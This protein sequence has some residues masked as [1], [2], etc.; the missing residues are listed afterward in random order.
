MNYRP[1]NSQILIKEIYYLM[2]E[3]IYYV[4]KKK[5]FTSP[6]ISLRFN[7]NKYL[8]NLSPYFEAVPLR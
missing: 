6:G 2:I 3:E 1:A 7:L 4:I 8:T 5:T